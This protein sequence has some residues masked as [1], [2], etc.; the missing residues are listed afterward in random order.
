MDFWT[1]SRRLGGFNSPF[2]ETEQIAFIIFFTF[3]KC[4]I[5]V[6]VTFCSIVS[7]DCLF[8]KLLFLNFYIHNMSAPHVCLFFFLSFPIYSSIVYKKMKECGSGCEPWW[9][10]EIHPVDLRKVPPSV[11]SPNKVSYKAIKCTVT[12]I[13]PNLNSVQHKGTGHLRCG[14][15]SF[16]EDTSPCC[17]SCPNEKVSLNRPYY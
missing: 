7:P 17:H 2:S 9:K 16:E 6:V 8:C 3:S 4:V 15:G 5:K 13:Q 10:C 1:S 12:V 11:W 14:T